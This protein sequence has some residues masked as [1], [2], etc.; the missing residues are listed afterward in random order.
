MKNF[1]YFP[2]DIYFADLEGANFTKFTQNEAGK[3]RRKYLILL[4]RLAP[5]L[6]VAERIGLGAGG[7]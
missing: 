7:V 3:I 1:N 5:T 2:N 4:E 6:S